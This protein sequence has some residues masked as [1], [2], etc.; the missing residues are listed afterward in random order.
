M[1]LLAGFFAVTRVEMEAGERAVP[2]AT[3]WRPAWL[4]PWFAALAGADEDNR[5]SETPSE[6]AA[7]SSAP[8]AVPRR[9]RG[10][11]TS[12]ALAAPFR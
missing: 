1:L 11:S 5:A 9:L 7:A 4:G 6:H 10:C 8:T 2:T 3:Q 12:R